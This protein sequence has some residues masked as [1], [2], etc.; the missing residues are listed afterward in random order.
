MTTHGLTRRPTRLASAPRVGLF[1]Q[2]GNGN[3]GNDISMESVLRYLRTDHPAAIVDA[4]CKG[5]T[6]VSTRYGIPAITINWYQRYENTASGV[7]A[8]LLKLLGKVIDPFRIGAWAARHDVVIIPGMGVMEASLPLTP[9]GLPYSFFLL[10]VSARIFG[11][12]VAFVSIGASEV[13]NR[14]TRALLN[15][16]AR[17]ASYRSYRDTPSRDVMRERGVDVSRDHVYSDIAFSI[18]PLPCGPGNPEIVGVGVIGYRGGDADR[19]QAAA[20]HASYVGAMKSFVRW[21]ID[22]DRSV[23]ILVGDENEPDK[24]VAELI[25]ADARAYRSDLTPERVTAEYASSFAELMLAMAPVG[26]VIAGRYHSVVCALRLG[27]P[28]LSLGYSPK[29]VALVSS[30]GLSEFCQSAKSPDVDLLIA[31]F[32]QLEKRQDE[33]RQAIANGNAAYERSVAAQFAE[34]SAVL[35]ATDGRLERS[36]TT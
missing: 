7:P 14:A 34:L 26:T 12:K 3:V 6:T 32:T 4:M 30:M 17:L 19:R 25:L 27:K 15:A 20:I 10:G 18:P 9:W 28:V 8:V 33:F 31:Q 22:N 16:S 13:K 36:S 5:P 24:E 35:L 11:T 1:G 23:R 29:F 21:L 2:L